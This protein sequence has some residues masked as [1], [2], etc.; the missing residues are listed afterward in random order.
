MRDALFFSKLRV[1]LCGWRWKSY[2]RASWL[3]ARWRQMHRRV[4]RLARDRFVSS[5]S[6]P[7]SSSFL[8]EPLES[9]L[10]LAAD[11]T[12]VVQSAVQ[13]DPAVPTNTASAVVQV[14]NVGNQNVSQSQ[15]GVYASL[16]TT[17]DASDVLLGTANT[18]QLNAG[19]SKNVT[20][21]LTIPNSLDAL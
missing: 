19:Q 16:D 21:N 7:S 18:G 5:P 20:T 10:L 6:N 1:M 13:L 14:Q 4:Q 11:L 3:K 17:L 9:R 12:G 2:R 8:L 15:V